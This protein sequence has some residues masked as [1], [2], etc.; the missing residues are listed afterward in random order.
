MLELWRISEGWCELDVLVMSVE[1]R[2]GRGKTDVWNTLVM[3]RMKERKS[4]VWVTVF[5]L[6]YKEEFV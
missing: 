4:E 6:I 3:G 1:Y 2:E 5:L